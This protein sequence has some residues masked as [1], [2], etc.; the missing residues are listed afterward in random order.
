MFHLFPSL[1]DVQVTLGLL[2]DSEGSQQNVRRHQQLRVAVVWVMYIYRCWYIAAIATC[3][4]L[5]ACS[6]LVG[7]CIYWNLLLEFIEQSKMLNHSFLHTSWIWIKVVEQ[8]IHHLL[9]QGFL[10]HQRNKDCIARTW[11]WILKM[12][13]QAKQSKSNCVTRWLQKLMLQTCQ[14]IKECVFHAWQTT[15]SV[16]FARDS[17]NHSNAEPKRVCTGRIDL[18]EWKP[19]AFICTQGEAI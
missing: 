4:V 18:Q 11:H 9:C 6:M 3:F 5:T 17:L 16:A 15:E 7:C 8:T 2:R 19:L 1:L 10:L 12:V 14:R 13:L